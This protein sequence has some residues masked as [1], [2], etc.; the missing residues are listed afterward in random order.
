MTPATRPRRTHY[1]YLL[2]CGDRTYYVGWTLDPVRRLAA[3]RR[4]RG[5]RYT[6]GRGPMR[7]V[8]LWRVPTLSAA[9]RL[10]YRLKQLPRALKHRLAAGSTA[11]RRHPAR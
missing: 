11:R 4:G 9:L 8:A 1:V 2:R 3:H 7:I 5:A 10:E 6:R